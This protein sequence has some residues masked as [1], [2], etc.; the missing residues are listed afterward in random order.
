[1]ELEEGLFDLLHISGIALQLYVG[2]KRALNHP[3]NQFIQ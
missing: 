2:K 3:E 1:M